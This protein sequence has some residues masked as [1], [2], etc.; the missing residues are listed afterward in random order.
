MAQ[1]SKQLG[2]S[3]TNR[4]ITAL[5]GLPIVII[6][7]SLGGLWLR[8]G[9]LA[10]SVLGLSEFYRALSGKGQNQ[11]DSQDSIERKALHFV[12]YFFSFLYF[13]LIVDSGIHEHFIILI[14]GF[15]LLNLMLTVVFFQKIEFKDFLITICGFFYV[16]FLLS[17]IYLVRDANIY[18]VWLI[19]TS[20]SASDT[21]AYFIGSKWGRHKLHG[22]PSPKKTWEGCVGGVLGAALVG[23]LYGQAVIN[24]VGIDHPIVL[25]SMAVSAVG[26]VFSQFGDLFASAIKRSVG[27]KDFGKVL[28]GHGGVLDR[29][30]SIMVTAPGIYM[31]L[32]LL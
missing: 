2:D 3:M 30:D 15:I 7:V 1:D 12:G 29:F 9:L 20:A 24:F 17:F 10:L 4:V 22:T 13:L 21:F 18:F 26:A 8:G 23:F 11:Q 6:L 27:I 31:V 32:I 14:A 16:T 5:V 28:P 25:H 19:F